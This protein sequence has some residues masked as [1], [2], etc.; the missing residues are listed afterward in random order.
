VAAVG[1]AAVFAQ[2]AAVAQGALL[3]VPPAS[4]PELGRAV[5]QAVQAVARDVL[6]VPDA[7]SLVHSAA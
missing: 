5:R 3:A 1:F 7:A 4:E 6:P 2:P